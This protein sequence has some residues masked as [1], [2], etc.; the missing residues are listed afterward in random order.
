[1]PSTPTPLELKKW[2]CT[3]FLPQQRCLLLYPW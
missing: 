3:P 2:N 1:M